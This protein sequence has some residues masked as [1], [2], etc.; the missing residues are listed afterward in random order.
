M[1]DALLGTGL[2]SVR[3]TFTYPP[4]R[5]SPS[6]YIP[7]SGVRVVPLQLLN[8]APAA[9]RKGQV[10]SLRRDA[11]AEMSR[12]VRRTPQEGQIMFPAGTVLTATH[13]GAR[14]L[15]APSDVSVSSRRNSAASR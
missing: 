13:L 1:I 8:W 10:P 12:R 7:R 3:C 5:E 4:F 6:A 15:D 9:T 11:R 2:T 14:Q